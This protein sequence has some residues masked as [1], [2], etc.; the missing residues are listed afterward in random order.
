SAKRD[1][2]I[3]RPRRHLCRAAPISIAERRGAPAQSPVM[4][5]RDVAPSL[6]RA[7]YDFCSGDRETDDSRP[8]PMASA[9]EELP[10]ENTCAPRRR[11]SHSTLKQFEPGFR[12][13]PVG[14]ATLYSRVRTR[15]RPARERSAE[16]D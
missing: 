2:R 6:E 11:V 16:F 14:E 4:I 12:F 10:P 9:S 5:L 13:L 3:Q 8:R 1:K 15:L 7:G